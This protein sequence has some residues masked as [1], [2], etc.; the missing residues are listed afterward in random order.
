MDNTNKPEFL[1][2]LYTLFVLEKDKR[3]F[4][5]LDL[6]CSSG[7]M[8]EQIIA[9]G[10]FAAGLEGADYSLA[11]QRS[12]WGRIPNNLFTCDVTSPFTLYSTKV[13][14][15]VGEEIPFR[16]DVITSWELIEHIP[17]GDKL[18]TLCKNVLD[19]LITDGYWM[20]SISTQPGYHHMTLKNKDWWL[21]YFDG[22]GLRNDGGACSIIGNDWPRGPNEP[23][24][25]NLALVRKEFY[26]ND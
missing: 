16:F 22:H 3:S 4:A 13:K 26:P 1:K 23:C 5:M 21:N 9:D 2:K 19:H 18:D 12:S 8:V 10:H 7:R 14:E 15:H 17:E 20:M 25:F 11:R 24:S 6:G